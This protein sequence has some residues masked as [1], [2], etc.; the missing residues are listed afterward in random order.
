MNFRIISGEKSKSCVVV[1]VGALLYL[2]ESAFEASGVSIILGLG[3]FFATH[4]AVLLAKCAFVL[5]KAATNE[6]LAKLRKFVAVATL[7]LGLLAVGCIYASGNAFDADWRPYVNGL[8]IGGLSAIFHL[9]A[10]EKFKRK[11]AV[12]GV[13]HKR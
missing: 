4:A 12:L 11:S 8:V 10:W 13:L 6:S 5:R 7:L 9:V 3:V 2:V 1:A